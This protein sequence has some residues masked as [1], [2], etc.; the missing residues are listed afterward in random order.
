MKEGVATMKQVNRGSQSLVLLVCGILFSVAAGCSSQDA[1]RAVNQTVIEENNIKGRERQI[2]HTE[3][4][5][6]LEAGK[7]YPS[8]ELPVIDIAEGSKPKWPGEKEHYWNS[9]TWRPAATIPNNPLMK[10]SS[11]WCS[12]AP[13]L[14]P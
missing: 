3:V 2:P 13:P 14:V 8:R 1:W 4:L 7:I 10:S 11:R 12:K 6:S 9:S 5:P